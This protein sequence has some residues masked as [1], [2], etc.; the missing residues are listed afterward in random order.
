MMNLEKRARERAKK[1]NLKKIILETVTFVGIIS[2]ATLLPNVFMAMKRLGLLTH[3]RQEETI[4]RA[5]SNLIKRGMLKFK[6]NHLEITSKGRL[7]LLKNISPFRDKKK[8]PKWDGKWR[9]L[10]FDIPQKR[11]RD[12]D[13]IRRA[14]VSVG[15]MYLQKSVWV[16][17]YD[18][19]ELVAL[20]KA[21]LKIGKDVLYMIVEELEYDKPVREY[22]GLIK[23]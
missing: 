12:R 1:A 6:D 2:F 13:L 16:Y 19:E 17:P 22:F 18:C 20:L 3:K 8:K 10:I 7:Y 5:R 14:L 11:K 15:F 4:K 21:D 23:D 9:V